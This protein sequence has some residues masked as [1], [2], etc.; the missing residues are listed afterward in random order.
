M[1]PPGWPEPLSTP[2]GAKT[3]GAGQVVSSG[4]MESSIRNGSLKKW[5]SNA[6]EA[7]AQRVDSGGEVTNLFDKPVEKAPV[8]GIGCLGKLGSVTEPASEEGQRLVVAREA[9]PSV[10]DGALQVARTDPAVEA[11]RGRDHVDVP[12]G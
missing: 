1:Q 12:A 10:A 2:L 8:V 3:P 11:E 4:A 6:G 9:W 5:L 7:L